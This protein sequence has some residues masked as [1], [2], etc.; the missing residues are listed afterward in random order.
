MTFRPSLRS[1]AA[2]GSTRR[3]ADARLGHRSPLAGTRGA[4]VFRCR[5][6]VRLLPRRSRGQPERSGADHAD[7]RRHP[8]Q[9]HDRQGHRIA[10]RVEH[11]KRVV[12]EFRADQPG[13]FPIYCN[14]TID[15]KCREMSGELVVAAPGERRRRPAALRYNPPPL[16]VALQLTTLSWLAVAFVAAM[17][18]ISIPHFG[19]AFV[20]AGAVAAAALRSSGTGCRHSSARS[21][22]C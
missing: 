1:S 22:S 18:E 7:G 3:R 8:S 15:E 16:N 6:Q 4:G 13:R 17:L 5:A 21:S 2:P 9:L 14:L 11:G 20:S 19:S 12:F 10:K